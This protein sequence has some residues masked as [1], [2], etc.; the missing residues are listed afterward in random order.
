M[1]WKC[2]T[3]SDERCP[4]VWESTG[5]NSSEVPALC[6]GCLEGVGGL[7]QSPRSPSVVPKI[8][9]GGPQDRLPPSLVLL[10]GWKGFLF[11]TR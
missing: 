4:E 6:T 10:R 11:R 1:R 7:G 9:V 5:C 2:M 8:A 3:E